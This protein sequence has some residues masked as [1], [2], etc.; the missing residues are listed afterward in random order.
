MLKTFQAFFSALQ[1]SSLILALR[2]PV[3]MAAV[4][5]IVSL[6]A[7]KAARPVTPFMPYMI[8]HPSSIITYLNSNIDREYVV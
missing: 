5:I 3:V 6:D 2:L 4:S 1:K 7:I 8:L